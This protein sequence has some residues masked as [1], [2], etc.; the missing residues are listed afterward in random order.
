MNYQDTI[1]GPRLGLTQ[2]E[3]DDWSWPEF[4]RAAGTGDTR[5]LGRYREASAAVAAARGHPQTDLRTF[6]VPADVLFGREPQRRDMSVSQAIYGG[7]LVGTAN[8]GYLQPFMGRSL[9]SRLP[10]RRLRGL[11]GN[12]TI[13]KASSTAG[14]TWLAEEGTT[15][16]VEAQPSLGQLS[17]TPKDVTAMVEMTHQLAL[18]AG[19]AGNQFIVDNLDLALTKAVDTALFA[20]SGVSGQ[21]QS[22]FTEPGVGAAAGAGI[23]WGDV[24]D[25]TVSAE[26]TQVG[27]DMPSWV[28]G[29]Q[30]AAVL[31]QRERAAGSGF[32]FDS[33]N[34]GGY[35]ATVSQFAP[36]TSIFLA[37]WPQIVMAGWGSLEV[38]VNP[39]SDFTRGQIGL[40]AWLSVD[41][42]C[43]NAAGL[44][45]ATEVS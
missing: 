37:D 36:T 26:T 28:L 18:Q 12:I 1:F 20:G 39:F 30:A 32:I 42:G 8:G 21:P 4:I 9:T 41:L 43:L 29:P 11:V 31:R 19:D 34:I 17:L 40:R 38:S 13:P 3:I 7:N 35:A 5:K 10:L 2:R 45:V 22:P 15:Q 44:S 14:T 27:P 23:T 33:G 16:I 6:C 25:L 24:C